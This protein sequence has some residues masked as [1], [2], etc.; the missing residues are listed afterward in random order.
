LCPVEGVPDGLLRREVPATS[1]VVA[2]DP[3]TD[4]I[5]AAGTAGM[6]DV[7]KAA[8]LIHKPTT[9]ACAEINRR[10][11]AEDVG[12]NRYIEAEESWAGDLA[13]ARFV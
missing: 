13:E 5:V 1:L 7:M 3:S 2:V 6:F 10:C 11:N 9:P 8:A 4:S 12:I